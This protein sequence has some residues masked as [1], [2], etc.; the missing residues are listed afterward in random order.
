MIPKNDWGTYTFRMR[1]NY[2][3]WF[4]V[5]VGDR[6]LGEVRFRDARIEK[7]KFGGG[8]NFITWEIFLAYL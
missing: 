5:Q 3:K 8:G 6:G 2:V 4:R 1:V 7:K